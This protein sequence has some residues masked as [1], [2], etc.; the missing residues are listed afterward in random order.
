[1]LTY[2][3]RKALGKIPNKPQPK[4]RHDRVYRTARRFALGLLLVVL[5]ALIWFT[6]PALNR[7]F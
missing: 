4:R 6:W 2:R 1:M 3:Q 7:P 5:G